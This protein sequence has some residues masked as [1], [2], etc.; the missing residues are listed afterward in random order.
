MRHG[1]ITVHMIIVHL[2]DAAKNVE[3]QKTPE[4]WRGRFALRRGEGS[5]FAAADHQRRYQRLKK[6]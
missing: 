5:G 2:S 1:I 3:A 4:I 6:R